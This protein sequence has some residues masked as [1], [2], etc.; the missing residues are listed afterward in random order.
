MLAS[1]ETETWRG[2]E[3]EAKRRSEVWRR[4]VERMRSVGCVRKE[5][6]R[7]TRRMWRGGMREGPALSRGKERGA[8]AP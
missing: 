1:S 4:K 6:R 2:L 5:R 7:E 8:R 3:G